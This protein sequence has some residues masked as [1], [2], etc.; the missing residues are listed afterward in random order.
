MSLSSST[1]IRCPL[2]KAEQYSSYNVKLGVDNDLTWYHCSCQSMFHVKQI[3]K[4]FFNED[5]LNSWKNI[6]DGKERFNYSFRNYIN[7]IEEMTYG[8]KFLDVGFTLDY[9]ITDMSERGWVSTG[10]DLVPNKYINDDFETFQFD[11]KFDFIHIGHCLESMENPIEAFNK[12]CSMLDSKGVLFI[13]HPAPELFHNVGIHD[14][15][16][17][18]HPKERKVLISKKIFCRLAEKNDMDVIL[19]YYNLSKRYPIWNDAH[20]IMQKRS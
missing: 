10:V 19:Y 14:F 15:L 17:F 9:N 1:A 11:D 4:K 18:T 3:D 13:T 2:C 7:F 6:K 12:A 16:H 20:I 8:R 5:Y